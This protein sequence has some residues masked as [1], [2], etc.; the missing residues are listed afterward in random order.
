MRQLAVNQY[1]AARPLNGPSSE[2]RHALFRDNLNPY[3]EESR[4]AP[5]HR[6]LQHCDDTLAQLILVDPLVMWKHRLNLQGKHYV[7]HLLS[8]F[9]DY[10]VR[11]T[12]LSNAAGVNSLCF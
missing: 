6:Q 12:S 10:P 8:A 2:I 4:M 3:A 7:L 9:V 5:S 11:Y 1:L